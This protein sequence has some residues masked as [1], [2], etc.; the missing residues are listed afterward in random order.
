MI[1]VDKDNVPLYRA[2]LIEEAITRLRIM[3]KLECGCEGFEI[4]S[5]TEQLDNIAA[6][7]TFLINY[8]KEIK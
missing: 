6:N 7:A 3:F 4:P 8:L 1:N 2:Q 5:V